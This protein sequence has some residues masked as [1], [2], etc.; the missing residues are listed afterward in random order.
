MG[1][2]S[3]LKHEPTAFLLRKLWEFSVGR[4]HLIVTYTCMFVLA[5]CVIL[6]PPIVFGAMV[7]EVQGHG[8]T[9]AN[10]PRILLFLGLLFANVLLFWA[11]HGPARVIERLV[12]F[13]A[14]VQYRRHLMGQV[15][16]LGL[17]WHGN[18][19]SGDTIDKV[20][21]AG[22]GIAGFG[23]N[24]FQVIQTAVR[25][26]G[27]AT[28]LCWF[29]P[30]I[31]A[32]AFV[33]VLLSFTVILRFDKRLVPQ[34]QGLNR[35]SNLASAKVFDVLSNVTT[36]KIL[37]IEQPLLESVAA[38]Y[39]AAYPLFR[40]NAAL[41]E[42]KWFAGAVCFQ[43]VAV[44]PLVGYV[45]VGVY[46]G[47]SIDAGTLSTLYMY[48]TNLTTVYSTFSS[49]YQEISIY[50]QRVLNAAPIE[51]AFASAQ[52][53]RRQGLGPWEQVSVRNVTFS[54]NG[55]DAKSNLLGVSLGWQ[56]GER[57]ALIGE[58]GAGKSTFLKV[59]HGMYDHA[60]GTLQLDDGPC[61][62]TSFAD[63]DLKT[64]LVPQEPE[65][66]SASLREN[67]TLGL[68]YTDAQIIGAAKLSTFDK[69]LAQIPEGLDAVINEKGVNL[70]G[71]QKQRLALTRAL[72]FAAEKD[73]VLLDEST[74]SVDPRNE[75][76]I[77]ENIWR[78]FANKTVVA[79]IHKL[80][81]LRLFDRIIMF[82]GGEVVDE[83]TFDSLL[84][85]NPTFR[86]A[87]QAFNASHPA[88]SETDALPSQSSGAP[89][90][91]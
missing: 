28:A 29:S 14:E 66:F 27:T 72:L 49:F 88:L 81:L 23:Q 47:E 24:V 25:L 82:A 39:S 32:A 15:L 26:L 61:H 83:G 13:A 57:I 73:I 33:L 4:R 69:V 77:Y 34:H 71:G 35:F 59:L 85:S 89:C 19:D 1:F 51:E 87:W 40:S 3:T 52:G 30:S 70:S 36:A 11:L 80:N 17:T 91:S 54:Y 45:C 65:V 53:R 22:D 10:L 43:A 78:A 44:L 90:N 6:L 63:I 41:H 5:N 16:Q 76:L 74:S 9:A 7:R 62:A 50:K 12:A 67:I 58:S 68:D 56:H 60:R 86:A 8:I 55:T 31:G 21:K 75:S 20:N 48:L 84:A 38:R 18:H 42:Y 2:A 37:H 46:Q 79:C 64:M